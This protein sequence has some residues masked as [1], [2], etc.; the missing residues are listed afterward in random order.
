VQPWKASDPML[1]TLEG[2]VTLVR[3]VLYLNA[4]P[5]MLVTGK[6]EMISGIVTAPPAPVYP[7]MET[8]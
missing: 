1:V 7:E 2:I 8:A 4:A 3:L 6:S 5:A